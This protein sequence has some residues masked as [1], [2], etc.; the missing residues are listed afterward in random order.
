MEGA[1]VDFDFY[2]LASCLLSREVYVN[3]DFEP[4]CAVL[5]LLLLHT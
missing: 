5:L 1:P 2:Q 3:G 4:I